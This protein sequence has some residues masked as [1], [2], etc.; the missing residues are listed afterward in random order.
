MMRADRVF[1]C[2]R[3]GKPAALV[4]DLVSTETLLCPWCIAEIRPGAM[5]AWRADSGPKL[6]DLWISIHEAARCLQSFVFGLT[7][8]H[9]GRFFRQDFEAAEMLQDEAQQLGSRALGKGE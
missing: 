3:C 8:V 9:H 6:A 2:D 1:G 7:Q 4:D 5:A